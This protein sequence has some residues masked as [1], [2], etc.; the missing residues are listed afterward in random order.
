MLILLLVTTVGGTVASSGITVPPPNFCEANV[1]ANQTTDSTQLCSSKSCICNPCF[2]VDP[3]NQCDVEQLTAC[4]WVNINGGVSGAN[5][6]RNALTAI[7]LIKRWEITQAVLIL[8]FSTTSLILGGAYMACFAVFPQ[9]M[10][11][12]PLSLAFWIY[13]CD[14]FVSLQFII[15]S[16]L[17]LQYHNPESNQSWLIASEPEVLC[18]FP[19]DSGEH[20]P[21][22][23][24]SGGV[25]SFML[26]AGVSGSIAFFCAMTH[27]EYRSI[28]NPFTKP[29]SRL[30]LYHL[31]CWS[32]VA[33]LSLPY[34]LPKTKV[35]GYGYRYSYIMCWSPNRDFNLQVH[36][37]ATLPVMLVLIVAPSTHLY[38]RHLL[39]IGGQPTQ[40]MLSERRDQ[41][42]QGSVIVTCFSLYWM[43]TGLTFILGWAPQVG[44]TRTPEHPNTRTHTRPK[45]GRTASVW[46]FPDRKSVV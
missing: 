19:P 29:R 30:P 6:T 18:S 26:Q 36:L 15:A 34:I 44:R 5:C 25:M 10:W 31:V 1:T 43:L 37:T 42:A 17:R 7:K 21:G 13:V 27:N 8:I 40:A 23:F 16:S 12:Y 46:L 22:C 4:P 41:L 32:A 11:R 14:F 38:S 28:R 35:T 3:V 9:K 20:H 45:H 24:C 39:R 2:E 33:L